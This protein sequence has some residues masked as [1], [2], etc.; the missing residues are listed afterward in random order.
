MTALSDEQ[1]AF[2]HEFGFLIF[3]QLLGADDVETIA[4]EAEVAIEEIYQGRE[5]GYRAG[6]YRSSARRPRSAPPCSRT[7]ASTAERPSCSM[8]A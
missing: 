2:F 4:R 5:G 1:V 6:G 3:R 7:R 8:R